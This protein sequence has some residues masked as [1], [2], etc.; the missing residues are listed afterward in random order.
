M[1]YPLHDVLYFKKEE[2]KSLSNAFICSLDIEGK[3]VIAEFMF[4][5]SS[6][7]ENLML[8]PLSSGCF[9]ELKMRTGLC[10]Y[11]LILYYDLF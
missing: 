1:M 7:M 2:K 9:L 10:L 3:P 6:K 8:S 4:L 11:K 5:D